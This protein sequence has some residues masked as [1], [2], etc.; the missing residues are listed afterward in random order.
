MYHR[1][2]VDNQTDNQTDSFHGFTELNGDVSEVSTLILY[3]RAEVGNEAAHKCDKR[4]KKIKNGYSF[5]VFLRHSELT[6]ASTR[7]N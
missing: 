7:I 6:V 1:L 2:S 4:R 5:F 3:N